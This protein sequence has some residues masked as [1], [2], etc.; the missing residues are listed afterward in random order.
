MGYK[1]QGG[2]I[3]RVPQE[4]LKKYPSID[5]SHFTGQA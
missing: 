3:T 4:I 5:V 2:N 1:A